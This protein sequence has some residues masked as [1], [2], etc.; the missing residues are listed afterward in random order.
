LVGYA[1]V[2]PEVDGWAFTESAVAV[3][4]SPAMITLSFFIDVS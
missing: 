3:R 1:A 4:N 2:V